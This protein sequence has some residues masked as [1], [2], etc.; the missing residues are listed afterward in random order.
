MMIPSQRHSSPLNHCHPTTPLVTVLSLMIYWETVRRCGL[1]RSCYD[2]QV[3]TQR[4]N[5][6]ANISASHLELDI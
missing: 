4:Y 2:L 6:K 1:F 3:L 5:I